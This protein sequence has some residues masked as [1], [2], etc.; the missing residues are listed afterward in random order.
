MA[1]GEQDKS[2]YQTLRM[3]TICATLLQS[4]DWKGLA[5]V[6]GQYIQV[7][8]LCCKVLPRWVS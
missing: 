2:K 8:P 4:S 5:A 3:H 1:V 7:F 6:A